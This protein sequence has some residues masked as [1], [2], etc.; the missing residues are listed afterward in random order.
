[1][2][3]KV[4]SLGLSLCLSMFQVV[5]LTVSSVS[6]VQGGGVLEQI[7][8]T[9]RAP[10]PIAGHYIA[11]V[12]PIKWDTRAI[13]VVYSMNTTLDPI[14]NP[15]GAAF[16]SVAD[17]KIALQKA[18]DQWNDIKTSYIDMKIEGT[19]NNPGFRGFDF[20]NELTFRT[21][22]SFGAIASSP[23]VS[24]IEDSNLEDG[25]DIDLDGDSD[26]SKFITQAKDYDGDGDIEFPAGFYKAGTILDNDVQFNTKA[27][28]G[29]R[30]TI[31]D[32][33]IDPISRS[34]DLM[35]VAVHEF[36]HSHGLSHT[37]DN[38][39]SDVDGTGA[40]MFP[41]I[42]TSDPIDEIG[43]RSISQDDISW[44][45]YMYQEGTSWDV[46]NPAYAWKSGDISFE[47][48]YGVITGEL[49]HGVYKE[50]IAGGHV[51]AVKKNTNTVV[52]SAFSGTTRI[53]FDPVSGGL[54]LVDPL[55]NIQNGKYSIPV[56]KGL[57]NVGVQAVDGTPVS[58]GSISLTAQIGSIFGQMNFLEEFYNCKES[59]QE[60]RLGQRTSILVQDGWNVPGKDI[61]TSDAISIYSS[62]PRLGFGFTTSPAGLIY[63]VRIPASSVTAVNPGGDFLIQGLGMET[64]VFDS[65]VVPQYAQAMLTTGKV[66]LDGSVSVD[67]AAPIV[68]KSGFIGQDVD[69]T[70][71]YFHN[72]RWVGKKVKAGIDNGT[73]TDLFLVL[74]L[75]TTTPFPG[76]SAFAPTIGVGSATPLTR[77]SYTSADGGNTW[78]Q[79]LV[80]NW[81]FSLIT[82]LPLAAE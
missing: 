25:E 35:C 32:A 58:A 39:I 21:S 14:P 11:N 28:N 44:S 67:L 12:I 52:A 26:V 79:S 31:N 75:P 68:A 50:P 63:A 7:D 27:S 33:E 9:G 61:V 59:D 29:L 48:K 57:Y 82:S 64:A 65:S 18:F 49:T 10:S 42:D 5:V 77:F 56:P 3:K 15:L 2:K 70:P 36:G 55:W 81:R 17:A 62:G 16:L 53:S 60:L 40:T 38:Q 72:P 23:S 78:S 76:Y 74:Q 19:T 54:Y 37:L 20:V 51:F 69:S 34:V 6:P 43:I 41:F 66:N 30:F 13:P 73:I 4:I 47:K 1:M 8:I 80:Y 22:T 45:S 24:L 71:F 46:N